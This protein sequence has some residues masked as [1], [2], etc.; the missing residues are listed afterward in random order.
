MG[1]RKFSAGR[2][3]G[4]A[5]WTIFSSKVIAL[6]GLSVPFVV[7]GYIKRRVSRK[8]GQFAEQL[9]DNL[10]VLA[11]AMRAGH[12]FIGAL[13]VVVDD[14]P[15]PSR[16]E[17]RRVIADEQLGVPLE[18][19]L[20]VVVERMES[21]E[22]EQV[23]LVA[24]VQRNSGGNTAEVLDRVTETIRERFELRRMVK[25]LTAQG[26]L[27]RWIV[28][29]LPVFL[30]TVITLINPGYM[31]VLFASGGGRLAL[32]FAGLMVIAGSFVIKRIV[33]IKV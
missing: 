23:A 5:S 6:L 18:D 26:R 9:P 2:N 25:T 8:R 28:S 4:A 11:S 17:F 33:N 13:S 29:L 20:H 15:E 10:Q 12:S 19:A 24:A 21:R 32:A 30:L 3:G 1:P 27:S 7:R 22:L 14:A 31:H 16:S